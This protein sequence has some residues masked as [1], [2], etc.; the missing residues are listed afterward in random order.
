V[1]VKNVVLVVCWNARDLL[2][3]VQMF[4]RAGRDGRPSTGTTPK[5]RAS[6]ATATI[7]Y[8]AGRR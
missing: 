4:G 6:A 5:E 2:D 3:M 8:A 7:P 1:D